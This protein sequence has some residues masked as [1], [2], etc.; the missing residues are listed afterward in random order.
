MERALGND[1]SGVRV[2]TGPPSERLNQTLGS[3]AFT[4]G[5]DIFFGAGHY[6]PQTPEG[7]RLIAHE[8]THVV[9]QGA[10]AADGVQRSP[11]VQR[12]PNRELPRSNPKRRVLKRTFDFEESRAKR[13]NDA[14]EQSRQRGEALLAEKRNKRTETAPTSIGFGQTTTFSLWSP[15][16]GSPSFGQ[17]F[18]EPP[19]SFGPPSTFGSPSFFDTPWSLGPQHVFGQTSFPGLFP[20]I[21]PPPTS[22]PSSPFASSEPF[23]QYVGPGLSFGLLASTSDSAFEDVPLPTWDAST[24]GSYREPQEPSQAQIHEEQLARGEAAKRDIEHLARTVNDT[25]E[26][27]D[28]FDLLQFRYDLQWIDFV[29]LGT[30]RARVV[31][32]INPEFEV[33]LGGTHL[34]MRAQGS[35]SK[36]GVPQTKVEWKTSQLTLDGQG[37]YIVGTYM[38]ANPLSMDHPTGTESKA[39]TDQKWMSLLPSASGSSSDGYVKGHLLNHDLGGIANQQNLFPIT[40]WANGQHKTYAEQY[41]KSGINNGYV[42]AYRVDIGNITEGVLASGEYYVNADLHFNFARLDATGNVVPKTHHK[43]TVKSR[44]ETQ[45]QNRPAGPW[46][47]VKAEYANDYTGGKKGQPKTVGKERIY[48]HKQADRGTSNAGLV[49]TLAKGNAF[50]YGTPDA[51]G[52]NPFAAAAKAAATAKVQ[53]LAPGP[54]PAVSYT[55]LP[56]HETRSNV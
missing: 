42:Y 35:D 9:Q 44:Y 51:F 30:P 8:L 1:F 47:D 4:T 41:I 15:S 46:P 32:K 33:L 22:E 16:F 53:S 10:G 34:E 6:A 5:R 50:T 45:K 29:E 24:F 14:M 27:A 48:K 18:F 55:Q 37:D 2:H 20:T 25:E 36:P 49:K 31:F 38:L 17:P 13:R 11:V 7:Q 19:S 21:G 40:G 54:P 26:M 52:S 3:N 23:S 43:G 56:A 12:N 28:Y 39:D